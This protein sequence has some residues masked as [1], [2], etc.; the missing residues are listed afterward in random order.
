MPIKKPR[1]RC[2]PSTSRFSSRLRLQ[3][4]NRA[5]VLPE[6]L[7]STA[8]SRAE[9][10]IQSQNT[11]E[12]RH[13]NCPSCEGPRLVRVRTAHDRQVIYPADGLTGA[14]CEEDS[15]ELVSLGGALST[16]AS[17]ALL[18]PSRDLLYFDKDIP[19]IELMALQVLDT[20]PA[21]VPSPLMHIALNLSEIPEKHFIPLVH[22]VGNSVLSRLTLVL[23][24]ERLRDLVVGKSSDQWGFRSISKTEL[25]AREPQLY[26]LG[27]DA[28]AIFSCS[29][30]GNPTLECS[31]AF[32]WERRGCE[33]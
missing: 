11:Q 23:T 29:T 21:R 22:A 17:E 3:Q 12:S 6:L 10:D 14:V 28:E 32:D 19:L 5:R 18:M 27:V 8:S 33:A 4:R 30:G 15:R 26:S 25:E 2:G 16:Y 20:R 24:L 1:S 7:L 9:G 31:F 13:H